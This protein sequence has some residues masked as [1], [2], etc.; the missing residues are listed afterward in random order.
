MEDE[1]DNAPMFSATF[2]EFTLPEHSAVGTSLTTIQ[3]RDR[4]DGTNAQI[5]YFIPSGSPFA[6]D[7]R[8][9]ILG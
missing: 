1:N 6:V 5:T 2:L 3:A 4:D 8:T 7:P 9:G